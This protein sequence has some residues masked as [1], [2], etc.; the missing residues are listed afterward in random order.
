[1]TV[2]VTEYVVRFSYLGDPSNVRYEQR[3]ASDADRAA[4]LQK[5]T[6]PFAYIKVWRLYEV[7]K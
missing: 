4:W 3:F 2:A 5:M 6:P 1:M 7:T